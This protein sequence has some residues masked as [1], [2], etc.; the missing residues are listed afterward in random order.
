MLQDSH[1]CAEAHTET[2]HAKA[3]AEFHW[4]AQTLSALVRMWVVDGAS[5]LSIATALGCSSRS[6]VSGKVSKLHLVGLQ[7]VGMDAIPPEVVKSLTDRHI[8]LVGL[9][10]CPTAPECASAGPHCVTVKEQK[11]QLESF[12]FPA[13]G[14]CLWPTGDIKAHGIS[15]CGKLALCGRPYCSEHMHR[16]YVQKKLK[17]H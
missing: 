13:A 4:T 8:E 2:P 14:G 12:S 9:T 5:M 6:A 3:E 10:E 16:A 15:F 17:N 7:G 1:T 11:L